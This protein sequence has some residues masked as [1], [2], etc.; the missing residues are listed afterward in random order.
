[1][2]RNT[3]Y[4]NLEFIK[5]ANEVHGS[6]DKWDYSKV[7]YVSSQV[8]IIIGCSTHGWFKQTP[9]KHLIGHGCPQCQGR[10][11]YTT[12]SWIELAMTAH[13]PG[14]Y[15]YP[16][17]VYKANDVK[18]VITCKLHGDFLQEPANHIRGH[19]CPHCKGLNANR[20][21]RKLIRK[22]G[23][24][25]S[26][27]GYEPFALNWMCGKLGIAARKIKC[28]KHVPIIPYK[29]KGRNRHHYPDFWIPSQNRI[30]EVKS[31]WTLAGDNQKWSEL[32]A[33]REAA[34]GLEYK[35]N[36]LCFHST[37]E[38]MQLPKKWWLLS[39]SELQTKLRK[40]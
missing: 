6:S 40:K 7:S 20:F 17:A 2:S 37:G 32:L 11:R 14:R 16:R 38:K 10:R 29:V 12:K 5:K 18:V 25:F 33:K 13:P 8:P 27:Q 26:L 4:T 24:K 15:T 31:W 30:V 39:R 34:V 21:L 3:P 19:G 22:G 1:M 23:L 28:G 9:N 35:Y 36:V